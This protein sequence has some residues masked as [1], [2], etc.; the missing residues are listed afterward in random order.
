MH[1][2][3]F[4]VLRCLDSAGKTPVFSFLLSQFL[5]AVSTRVLAAAAA[6]GFLL[7]TKYFLMKTSGLHRTTA[8]R[9]QAF[10]KVLG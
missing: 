4:D 1:P 7:G 3:F 5:F 8:L 9:A 6:D 10:A 2:L